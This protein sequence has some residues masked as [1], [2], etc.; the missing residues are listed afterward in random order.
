MSCAP[1]MALRQSATTSTASSLQCRRQVAAVLW[2]P[3]CCQAQRQVSF[4]VAALALLALCLSLCYGAARLLS[5]WL[6]LLWQTSAALCHAGNASHAAIIELAPSRPVAQSDHDADMAALQ[7]DVDGKDEEDDL[8]TVYGSLPGHRLYRRSQPAGAAV[9]PAAESITLSHSDAVI[10]I[11]D[12]GKQR[13]LHCR[14]TLKSRSIQCWT[15]LVCLVCIAVDDN[16][17]TWG[18][19][20]E[21]DADLPGV[22]QEA[23]NQD[24][25]GNVRHSTVGQDMASAAGVHCHRAALS[26]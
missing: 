14:Q 11:C 17:L 8:G 22:Q 25:A 26:K 18:R 4:A 2:P 15:E 9:Q 24:G 3:R 19:G 12:A 21:V 20:A 6:Q 16:M 1:F 5:L 23:A 13:H 7:L 10:A